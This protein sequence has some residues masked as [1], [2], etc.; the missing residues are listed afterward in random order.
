MLTLFRA[1]RLNSCLF[2]DQRYL[3]FPLRRLFSFF[4]FDLQ[5]FKIVNK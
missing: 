4:R 5:L 3:F 1:D 2:G